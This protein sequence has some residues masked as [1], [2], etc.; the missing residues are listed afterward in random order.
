MNIIA[1]PWENPCVMQQHFKFYF[2]LVGAI[3]QEK[4]TIE[5][6]FQAHGGTSGFLPRAYG[7]THLHSVIG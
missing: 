4:D 3:S 6:F 2:F 5:P 1:A 7:T